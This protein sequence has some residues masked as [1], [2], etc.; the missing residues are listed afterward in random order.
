MLLVAP[1]DIP[2]L[3]PP[4]ALE[5]LAEL[6]A[7]AELTTSRLHANAKPAA[8]PRVRRGWRLDASARRRR[9]P[10]GPHTHTR[11]KEGATAGWRARRSLFLAPSIALPHSPLSCT[12]SGRRRNQKPSGNLLLVMLMG[13]D[14]PATELADLYV[15]WERRL[16]G[17]WTDE[18]AQ[19]KATTTDETHLRWQLST[20]RV[21]AGGMLG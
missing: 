8:T 20:L 15:V 14:F 13:F 6:E 10:D 18:R 17:I 1:L 16:F 9:R 21:G 2:V 11:S 12:G 4:A 5:L 3:A 19:A 7:V